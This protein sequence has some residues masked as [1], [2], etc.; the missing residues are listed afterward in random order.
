MQTDRLLCSGAQR[1][2]TAGDFVFERGL[3][4]ERM[5][6][7]KRRASCDNV[8]WRWYLFIWADLRQAQRHKSCHPT[9]HLSV[10]GPTRLFGPDSWTGADWGREARRA[11]E[12]RAPAGEAAQHSYSGWVGWAR[13]GTRAPSRGHGMA[14]MEMV[15]MGSAIN[16]SGDGLTASAETA[17]TARWTAR[18]RGGVI[19]CAVC[20]YVGH[21]R[22]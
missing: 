9:V 15:R 8:R 6:L 5:R 16:W 22:T 4:Y 17:V 11:R 10:A 18:V 12:A 1:R 7:C 14:K 13:Q 21:V 19:S 3:I 20:C 2:N